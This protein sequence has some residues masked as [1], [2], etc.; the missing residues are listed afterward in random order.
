LIE[1]YALKSAH[2]FVETHASKANALTLPVFPFTLCIIIQPNLGSLAYFCIEYKHLVELI[3]KYFPGLDEVMYR[4]FELLYPIYK[5]WNN[6][7]N[8]VSRN[9]FLF[10]YE[11]HVLH[12]LAIAALFKLPNNAQVLDAGTGGGL[13]GIPL[14]IFFQNVHFH[15]VDSIQKKI[16]AVEDIARQ[17]ELQNVTATCSRLENLKGKYHYIVGRAVAPLQL[18]LK[19]TAHLQ[20][21]AASYDPPGG[22]LYLKGGEVEAELSNLKKLYHVH[23]LSLIYSEPY[24]ETKVLIHLPA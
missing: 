3:S 6:K 13:P 5:D 17:L 22:M 9:D 7:I 8:L 1:G 16:R 21:K 10:F 12:S 23:K 24:F 11:R 15:L 4:R 2:T 19:C 20:A 14:A 18:M